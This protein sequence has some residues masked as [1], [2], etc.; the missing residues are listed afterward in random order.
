VGARLRHDV[1]SPDPIP[2]VSGA[3]DLVFVNGDVYTVDG[4]RPWAHAVAVRAGRV[5]AV[6]DDADIRPL[7][8]PRTEVVDL[9]GRL[10]LPGFQ[11]SHVHPPQGGVEML[12]CNLATERTREG[13]RRAIARYAEQNPDLEW[14]LGGGWSMGAFPGGTPTIADLDDVCGARPVYLP[15]R[16][17]HS[18]WVS[19]RALELAGI[20]S[21]TP[22]P[23]D[24]RIER[25]AAGNPSGSLHEGAMSLVGRLLPLTTSE[26]V[27]RGLLGAQAY[28]H[29]LGITAWQDAIVGSF[30]GFEDSFDVYVDLD[31]HDLLTA[32]VVG[33]MW[34]DRKRGAEQFDGLIERRARA[35]SGR[36][37]ATSVKIM[38]DGVCETFTAAMLRPYLDREGHETGNCGLSFVD[39]EALTRYVSLLDAAGFQV[40]VHAIGDRAVREALDAIEAARIAAD[41]SPLRAGD[42]RHHLAHL[43]VVHPDD[44]D[45]FAALGVVANFQPLWACADAQMVELTMPYLGEERSTWQYPIG[46]LAGLGTRLAFGSDWPVSSPDPLAEMHVATS[47]TLAPDPGQGSRDATPFLA[48]EKVDLATAVRAF[49]LGSA[50][51]NHL[52]GETGSITPGKF[53]DLAV[54]D[55]NLF[56]IDRADGG[57]AAAEVLATFVEGRSVF[58]RASL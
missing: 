9:V 40:H 4:A 17:H 43:Q 27:R 7:V 46:S 18:A 32:R 56:G 3:A 58:E 49:T 21:A 52:D 20:T 54:I 48:S 11:D 24:G 55:R 5:T 1:R 26:D 2:E 50:F 6:G 13:F 47:R 14:I 51:V 15:N 39:P 30:H 36:F 10:L 8:G 41:R 57:L 28:L 16:D 45:R 42:H 34:W 22:D 44:L 31:E 37:R 38:Q 19:S 33:A 25:D 29:S 53:A 23:P 35:G 12:R